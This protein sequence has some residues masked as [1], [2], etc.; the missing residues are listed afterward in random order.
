MFRSKHL[1]LI[2]VLLGILPG[3]VS[4][5]AAANAAE[6][7]AIVLTAFGTS[8]AAADTYKHVDALARKRFPGYEIRW[9]FT[10]KKV[11]KKVWEEQRQKLQDLPQVLQEL[12]GAGFTRVAVQ[13]LHVVPGAEWDE[14]V[15]ESRQVPG[16]RVALGKP[17]LEGEKDR[18]LVLDLL[19]ESF[20]RDLK[21]NAVVLV[22]HGSPTPRGEAAYL[23]FDQLLRQRFPHQ[24]VF[25][26]TVE[27]KPPGEKALEAVQA[28]GADSVVFIPLLLVAGEHVNKDILGDGPDSWKSRLLARRSLKVQGIRQGLGYR[29]EIVRLYLNHLD[30][31]LKTLNP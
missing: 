5:S 25:L 7:P 24:N 22:G 1:A 4:W 27:G 17:L 16:I 11:S 8:T 21:K 30:E 23:A 31:A 10:S 15:Q 14:V 29:D 2:A 6:Q 9:A 28:S 12:K 13:S 20:P 18:S 19:K 3:L 26:G